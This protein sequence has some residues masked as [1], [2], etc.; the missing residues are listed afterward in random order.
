MSSP[1]KERPLYQFNWQIKQ[2]TNFK[3]ISVNNIIYSL[4]VSINSNISPPD[5]KSQKKFKWKLKFIL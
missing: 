4:Y 1:V 3:A 5:G 2:C